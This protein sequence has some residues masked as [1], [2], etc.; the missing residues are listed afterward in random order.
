LN[1]EKTSFLVFNK[2]ISAYFVAESINITIYLLPPRVWG[3]IGPHISEY[4]SSRNVVACIVNSLLIFV[5]ILAFMYISQS[6]VFPGLLLNS[7]PIA[8]LGNSLSAFSP[9]WPSLSCHIMGSFS[10]YSAVASGSIYLA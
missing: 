3:A 2:L 1:S 8:A 9:I 5:V 4:I 10:I 6:S 7:H